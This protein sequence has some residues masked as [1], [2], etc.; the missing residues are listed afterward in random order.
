MGAEPTGKN[1]VKAGAQGQW[2]DSG[3]DATPQCSTRSMTLALGY[4]TTPLRILFYC[5]TPHTALP[6]T[7]SSWGLFKDFWSNNREPLR[8]K[9]ETED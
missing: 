5:I 6:S 3:F 2:Q 8:K 9:E 7:L 4:P 1:G